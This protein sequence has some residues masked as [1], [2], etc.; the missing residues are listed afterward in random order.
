MRPAALLLLAL[1]AVRAH[2]YDARDLERCARID[3]PDRRLACFDAAVPRP[4]P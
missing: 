2:A 3:A 4:M 1:L